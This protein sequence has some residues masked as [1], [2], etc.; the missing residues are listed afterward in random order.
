M[1]I[2]T[3]TER[4]RFTYCF[5]TV[6]VQ[7]FDVQVI[8]NQRLSLQ[9]LT[10]FFWLAVESM[11]AVFW[12]IKTSVKK[13]LYPQFYLMKIE[14]NL[15]EV[16]KCCL[17]WCAINI[18]FPKGKVF[19]LSNFSSFLNK[20]CLS[21]CLLKENMTGL[22]SQP[23]SAL[24]ARLVGKTRDVCSL[25]LLILGDTPFTITRLTI[26]SYSQT[27]WVLSLAFLHRMWASRLSFFK[28]VN[29]R[30]HL[31]LDS[32]V[33]ASWKQIVNNFINL[34]ARWLPLHYQSLQKYYWDSG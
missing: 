13:I 18:I 15:L 2:Y 14:S 34:R 11:F 7:Y 4:N 31:I 25:R 30:V 27:S 1:Q 28:I 33:S 8:T 23:R 22:I 17:N 10:D 12:S 26:Q 21:V 9:R 29:S 16:I 32:F 5:W 20:G 19:P 24:T 3:D 6:A